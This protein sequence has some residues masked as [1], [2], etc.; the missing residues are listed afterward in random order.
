[1]T[2]LDRQP[3]TQ[4]FLS[5][6]SFK[7][8]VAKLPHVS[9][10]VQKTNIPG[11]SLPPTAHPNPFIEIP[12]AGDHIQKND[13][14]VNFKIDETLQGYKEV[15]NWMNGLGFPNEYGEYKQL[16]QQPVMSGMGLKSDMTLMILSSNRNPIV[17]VTLF[18]AFP[19]SLTNIDFDT[20]TTKTEYPNAT[21]TFKYRYF[22]FDTV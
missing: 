18:D 7:F 13:F 15:S 8:V 21:A 3:E 20:T 14:Y 2:V 19:I 5:N 9:F 6:Y 16:A 22:A 17:S 10:F 1:M 4:N 12:Y 11:I